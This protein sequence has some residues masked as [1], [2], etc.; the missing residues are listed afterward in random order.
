[1]TRP[2]TGPAWLDRRIAAGEVILTDGAMGTELEARGVPMDPSVWCGAAMMEYGAV[3]RAIH[4]DYIRAGAEVVITNTFA[5]G[6]HALAPSGHGDT[7]AEV[8]AKAVALA[9]EARD[10]V[11]DR[12]V[13]VAGSISPFVAKNAGPEW[14]TP[15]ALAASFREQAEL[16]AEAGV[17]LIALEMLQ[18]L[19]SAEPAVEA[20]L[21]TGL[22]VWVGFSCRRAPG[23]GL[24]SFNDPA[25][26]FGAVLAGIVGLGAGMMV[27]MHSTLDDTAA[28]L[29]LL[30]AH[31]SGPIGAYPNSG[32]FIMPN[33]QFVDIVSP[34][35][36]A[37]EAAGWV[38]QGAQVIGGCCGIG[39]AHIRRLGQDWP[40]GAPAAGPDHG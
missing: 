12:P 24:V 25:D 6:R 28:G 29:A 20:A 36:L 10:N 18:H 33:W 31:W 11:A 35:A 19:D 13:A 32:H 17:D 15:S 8:N 30:R 16:L 4:E 23:G 7:V 22:P 39:P 21:A 2:A 9:I 26:D 34:D 38:G 14:R 1:M 27:I 37:A 5:T 3:V 40:P